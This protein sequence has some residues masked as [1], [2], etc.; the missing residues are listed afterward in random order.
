MLFFALS[1]YLLLCAS[2]AAHS[3]SRWADVV[4]LSR[5]VRATND[6][7]GDDKKAMAMITVL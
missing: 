1:Q 7:Y 5:R 2:S 6:D 4:D 3:S